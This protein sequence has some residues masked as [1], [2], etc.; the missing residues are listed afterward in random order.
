MSKS[1]DD[2]TDGMI[3]EQYESALT[4]LEH[5]EDKVYEDNIDSYESPI[6]DSCSYLCAKTP[7]CV[8]I[9]HS[10]VTSS[11]SLVAMDWMHSEESIATFKKW[12]VKLHKH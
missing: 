6:P 7:G 3:G 4:A 2:E 5:Q 8:I 12:R 11:C 1:E 10:K 9:F